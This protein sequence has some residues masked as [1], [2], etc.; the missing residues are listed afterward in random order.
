MYICV[1]KV[2]I[3]NGINGNKRNF[4]SISSLFTSTMRRYQ[5]KLFRHWL[6]SDDEIVLFV[7]SNRKSTHCIRRFRSIDW[8][9]SV[10]DIVYFISAVFFFCRCLRKETK[11]IFIDIYLNAIDFR[12]SAIRSSNIWCVPFLIFIAFYLN[13]LSLHCVLHF[14]HG[15]F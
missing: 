4:P 10:V 6:I 7:S 3:Y 1:R 12:R 14:Y 11:S 15:I 9:L 2:F 5:T 8:Y 13:L